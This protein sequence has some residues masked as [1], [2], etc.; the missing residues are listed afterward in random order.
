VLRNPV[1]DLSAMIHLSDIPDWCYIEALGT[2]VGD[3]ISLLWSVALRTLLPL[4]FYPFLLIFAVPPMHNCSSSAEAFSGLWSQG[5]HQ[6]LLWL[7]SAWHLSR[8]SLPCTGGQKADGSTAHSRGP[9]A[10]PLGLAHC[11]RR[12][13]HGA[14]AVPAGCQGPQVRALLRPLARSVHAAGSHRCTCIRCCWWISQ[15]NVSQSQS[16]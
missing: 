7:P 6:N 15:S 12:Q 3:Q 11:A 1:L 16:P 2:E 10:I 9:G 13:G 5:R 8:A 14:F 4:F